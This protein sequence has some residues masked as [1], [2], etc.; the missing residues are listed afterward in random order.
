MKANVFKKRIT[1]KN[2]N[3]F[4]K[5]VTTLTKK[6]GTKV[7]TEVKFTDDIKARLT[8]FPV[9]IVISK[10]GANFSTHYYNGVDRDGN[11]KEYERN[12]LWVSKVDRI[13]PYEDTS[14][15]DFE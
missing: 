12:T 8:V 6:D 5:Y 15:D 1:A 13:E 9:T 7:Y 4:D 14:L 3:K 11:E 10:G 2:G